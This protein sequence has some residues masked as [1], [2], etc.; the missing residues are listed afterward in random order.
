MKG[1]KLD[2]EKNIAAIGVGKIIGM[3]KTKAIT[4]I[5]TGKTGKRY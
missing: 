2:G 5:T 1:L 3:T 4:K